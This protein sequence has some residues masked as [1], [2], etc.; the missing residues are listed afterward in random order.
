MTLQVVDTDESTTEL[1]CRISS[2]KSVQF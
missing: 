2:Y 1:L